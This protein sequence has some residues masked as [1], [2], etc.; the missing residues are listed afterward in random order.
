MKRK[1]E[2]EVEQAAMKKQLIELEDTILRLLSKAEGNILDDEVLTETL[3]KPK[4]ASLLIARRRA[5]APGG[6]GPGSKPC[7]DYEWVACVSTV[8]VS[9]HIYRTAFWKAL[10]RIPI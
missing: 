3:Q 8:C 7:A 1:R 6:R 5:G 9:I 10:H 2:L 4:T